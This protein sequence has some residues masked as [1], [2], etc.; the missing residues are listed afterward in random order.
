MGRKFENGTRVQLTTKAPQ[1]LKLW[2]KN[3]VVG[4]MKLAVHSYTG[5]DSPYKL[6]YTQGNNDCVHQFKQ[7][8]KPSTHYW[9]WNSEGFIKVATN[10]IEKIGNNRI[11]DAK[12][13][14]LHQLDK[15]NDEIKELESTKKDLSSKIKYMVDNQLEE[16]KETEYKAYKILELMESEVEM[17]L[18]EKAKLISKLVNTKA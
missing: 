8:Q 7:S 5:G 10:Y 16:F 18:M 13:S 9:N 2:V 6:G 11:V 1:W 17:S 15:V 12:G 3:N 4:N 14:L